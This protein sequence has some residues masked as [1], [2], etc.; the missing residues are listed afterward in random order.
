LPKNLGKKIKIEIENR[1]RK[2]PGKEF[3]NGFR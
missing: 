3:E 1:F 2:K